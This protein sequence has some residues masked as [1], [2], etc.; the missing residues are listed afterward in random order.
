MYEYVSGRQLFQIALTDDVVFPVFP[1]LPLLAS[2]FL[3]S[4]SAAATSACIIT[5]EPGRAG[6]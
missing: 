3:L 1:R 2:F 6:L 5:T 4:V